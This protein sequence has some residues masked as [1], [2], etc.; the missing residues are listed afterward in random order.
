MNS[1]QIFDIKELLLKV[2]SF[3][4]VFFFFNHCLLE[5]NTEMLRDKII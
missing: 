4:I 2:L 3:I 1:E 5:I